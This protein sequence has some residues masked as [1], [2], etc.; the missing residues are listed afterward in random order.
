MIAVLVGV[1]V[2]G[3][4]HED[5][6]GDVADAFGGGRDQ[7]DVARIL[8]DPRQGTFGVVAIAGAQFL[9][10]GAL[11]SMVPVDGLAIAVTAHLIGR[12][13]VVVAMRFHRSAGAGLAVSYSSTV[14]TID[15]VVALGIGVGVGAAASGIWVVACLAIALAVVWIVGRLALKKLGGLNGDVLGAIEQISESA[16]LVLGAAA[17]HEAWWTRPAWWA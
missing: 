2:T 13:A 5:G 3:G 9:R 1:T 4:L 8:K 10:A 12:T 6:L 16:I 11:G 7:A 15:L 14:T 17:V